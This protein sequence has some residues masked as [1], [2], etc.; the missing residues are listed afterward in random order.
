MGYTYTK[1]PRVIK[2]EIFV[3]NVNE[4]KINGEQMFLYGIYNEPTSDLGMRGALYLQ[5]IVKGK[6]SECRVV[7]FTENA[8]LT[9]VCVTGDV[10]INR[11]L[12]DMGFS[13]NIS[14]R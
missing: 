10:N 14:L 11:K 4:I 5:N 2:G 12:L 1:Q 3:V 13:K 8:E 6:E 9:A 7:A